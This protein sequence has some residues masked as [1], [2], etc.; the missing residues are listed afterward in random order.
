VAQVLLVVRRICCE[1]SVAPESQ[2][3]ERLV[4]IMLAVPVHPHVYVVAGSVLVKQFRF[5]L[6]ILKS[7][8]GDL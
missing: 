4:R 5:Q 1:V 7:L 6:V 2:G 8:D 3:M